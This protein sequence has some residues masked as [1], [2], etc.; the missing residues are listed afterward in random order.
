MTKKILIDTDPGV[1]DTMAILFALRSPEL[2]VIGL[3]AIFGNAF[4][5]ITAKNALHLVELENNQHIPVAKGAAVPLVEPP[6]S[7]GMHVHGDDGMGGINLP[8]PDGELLGIPAAQFIVETILANP[9]EL[10]LVPIGPL[11]NIA[12]AV[13]LE[14]RI[15][16][17]VKEVVIMGGTAHAEGNASPVAEANIYNDPHAAAIVF[18]AGWPLTM[19]GLDVT[20]KVV[21]TKNYLDKLCSVG[22]PATEMIRQVLPF[23]QQFHMEEYGLNG[24]LHTHDPSAIAYLLDPALFQAEQIPAFVETVGSCSGQTVL[25]R[26]R[27]LGEFKEINVCLGVDDQSVLDLFWERLTG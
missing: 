4:V 1:D 16:D 26:Q 22:N 9:G 20:L 23:Y 17:L 10:T 14:P 18:N 19:V 7:M 6:R 21:M 8:D 3:S 25:D 5:D 2:E 11:T 15:V 13:R 27:Q 12:L 24:D